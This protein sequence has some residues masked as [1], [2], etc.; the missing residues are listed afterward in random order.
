MG[1]MKDYTRSYEAGFRGLVLLCLLAEGND[2]CVDAATARPAPPASAWQACAAG[3]NANCGEQAQRDPTGDNAATTRLRSWRSRWRRC[4]CRQRPSATDKPLCHLL[5]IPHRGSG[6]LVIVH[7]VSCKTQ[8]PQTQLYRSRSDGQPI[9]TYSRELK[10]LNPRMPEDGEIE[11]MKKIIMRLYGV[12]ALGLY[13]CVPIYAQVQPEP[14][15]T[16]IYTRFLPTAR[17]RRR[18]AF[19]HHR[20]AGRRRIPAPAGAINS[21]PCSRIRL[22]SIPSYRP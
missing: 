14:L 12:L 20:L 22:V 18:R 17:S 6:I 7:L 9:E 1:V 8:L 15:S 2:V 19:A 16:Y 11:A 13:L 10:P 4:I 5:S 21:Q 3:A